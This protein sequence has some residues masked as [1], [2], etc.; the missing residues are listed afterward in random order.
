MYNN[1]YVL[2]ESSMDVGTSQLRVIPGGRTDH[3]FTIPNVIKEYGEEMII[4][5][6]N[7]SELLNDMRVEIESPI[8]DKKYRLLVGHNAAI[9][10][11]NDERP[12]DVEKYENDQ[13]YIMILTGVAYQ[14]VKSIAPTNGLIKVRHILST[15]LPMN[16]ATNPK[17]KEVFIKRLE[18]NI[19]FVKFVD[20]SKYKNTTV[21]I[22][23]EKVIVNSEGHLAHLRL[24]E[25]K[26]QE[27]GLERFA[28]WKAGK[29]GLGDLG[30]YSSDVSGFNGGRVESAW[31]EF[32]PYGAAH[33]QE[34]LLKWIHSESKVKK[35]YNS[36]YELNEILFH[37]DPNK[38][39]IVRKGN[40]WD[41]V[42]EP[43]REIAE[44]YCKNY[45]DMLNDQFNRAD[46]DEFY[47]V[48][49][50]AAFLRPY[51]T[52]LN[53]GERTQGKF[54]IYFIDDPLES[55]LMIVKGCEVVKT[56][57]KQAT[58]IVVPTPVMTR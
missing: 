35:Q 36:R 17:K 25:L 42:E 38:R 22:K 18:D 55:R 40:I 44:N 1:E 2:T 45:M 30:D 51:I 34:E 19:H 14:A 57:Y 6:E 33:V 31:C 47:L 50:G 5:D 54:P 58:G 15:V 23:F 12:L 32:Y 39:Y 24:C 21:E 26:L 41:S 28:Q 16:E 56:K 8:F 53:G 52:K 27:L 13:T 46:Y 48:G 10:A 3:L 4:G 29:I 37:P 11:H 9:R 7:T 43:L 20:T 49:G